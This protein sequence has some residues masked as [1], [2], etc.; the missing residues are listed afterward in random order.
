MPFNRRYTKLRNV[1][2]RSP[3]I[4]TIFLKSDHPISPARK[5]S[6]AQERI[7]MPED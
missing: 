6:L 7:I 4:V 1:Q 5:R 3:R 2:P